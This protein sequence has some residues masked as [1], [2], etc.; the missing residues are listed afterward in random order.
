MVLAKSELQ[1]QARKYWLEYFKDEIEQLDQLMLEAA[2]KGE[3]LV[4][5]NA[6]DDPWDF[7]FYNL[8]IEKGY[9]VHKG[10]LEGK[11]IIKWSDY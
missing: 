2:I 1:A 8:Y 9:S 10:L 11:M 5:F 7:Q 4:E 6:L 3:T